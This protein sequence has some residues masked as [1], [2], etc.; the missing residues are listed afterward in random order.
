[1]ELGDVATGQPVQLVLEADL[2]AG[3]TPGTYETQLSWT[4]GHVAPARINENPV[5]F[6]I[7]VA[8]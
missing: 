1:M 8:Q 4:V 6:D 2:A 5:V 3:I 7:E